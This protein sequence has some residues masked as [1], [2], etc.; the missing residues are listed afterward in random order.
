[1]K[2]ALIG[3][4]ASQGGANNLFLREARALASAG[5]NTSILCDNFSLDSTPRTK[6]YVIASLHKMIEPKDSNKQKIISIIKHISP[7]I[8]HFH[9]ITL[10][11]DTSIISEAMKIAPVIITP[12][13]HQY[14][15]P[16]VKKIFHRPLTQC[17][18]QWSIKCLMRPYFMHCNHRHP[19]KLLGTFRTFLANRKMVKRVTCII[20]TCNYMYR[21][22]L[23]AGVPH[24]NIKVVPPIVNYT[25]SIP[26]RDESIVL[27]AGALHPEKGA[28]CL[29]AASQH[30]RFPHKIWIAGDG[31]LFN[32]LKEITRERDIDNVN[33][34]G[35]VSE[36]KLSDLY[37]QASVVVMPSLCPETF[38]LS[39]VE[40][41]AAGRPVVAFD[42]GGISEW[43]LDGYNGFLVPVGNVELLANRIGQL[44]Q[45]PEL[46]NKMGRNGA[47]F[48]RKKFSSENHVKGL[49]SVYEEAIAS[50]NR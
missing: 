24:E 47:K 6:N 5:C 13:S 43:L 12:H 1:M 27:F 50:F 14:S 11:Q 33:F 28:L 7:D 45:D 21:M 8:I 4:F 38:G 15:C 40:A 22:I 48:V 42:V 30:I 46:S 23:G 32:Q 16:T 49:L 37:K 18:D 31:W 3:N 19:K 26:K 25:D 2:I 44:L 29:M 41:L 17:P 10:L 39:G 34:W 9:L 35:W 20:V 36:E